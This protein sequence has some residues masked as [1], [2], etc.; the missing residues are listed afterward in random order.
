[1]YQGFTIMV[2]IFLFPM[3]SGPWPIIPGMRAMFDSFEL[4]SQDM[5]IS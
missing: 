5:P 3:A 1:M 4:R 2:T